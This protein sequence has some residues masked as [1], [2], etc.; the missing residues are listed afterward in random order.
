[1]I[2]QPGSSLEKMQL[3]LTF[4]NIN[5][6]Y[7]AF[8][9]LSFYSQCVST[10]KRA[11]NRSLWGRKKILFIPR[12]IRNTCKMQRSLVKSGVTYCK[13]LRFPQRWLRRVL[14]SRMWCSLSEVYRRLTLL[15]AY[16]TVGCM[17]GLRLQ[18]EKIDHTV[19]RNVDKL[20]Q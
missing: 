1:M 5:F 14:S 4:W 13:G 6:F 20:L 3:L 16:F 10:I 7:I 2:A 15:C 9:N 8:K 18:R 11:D 12:I 19:L 17:H